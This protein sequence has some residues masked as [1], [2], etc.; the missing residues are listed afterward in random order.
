MT[1]ERA[2]VR[3]AG[4]AAEQ[5]ASAVA[6]LRQLGVADRPA[7]PDRA[8]VAVPLP[9]DRQTGPAIAVV[10][11]PGRSRTT[12]ELLGA[13][14][15]MAAEIRGRVVAVACQDVDTAELSARGA[16]GVIH[17]QGAT[18][19][20][21][22]ARGLLD[23]CYQDPPWA[24]LAPSTMWGRE[25]CGR[26]AAHLGAG[27]TGDAVDLAV[28]GGRLVGWKP[29]FGG[30]V[31]AAITA[32]SEIQL[33]TVR[34]GM[35]PLPRRRRPAP[36]A[37]TRR[38]V[39]PRGRVVERESYRDDDYDTLVT[40]GAVV[41]VGA[42]VAPEEYR[43]LEPLLGVLSAEL[44]GTR[45]V[46][47]KGWLPRA[48]Q[49][50]ITGRSI[51]PRLYMGI[52]LSGK[53]NHMVGVRGAGVIL[54]INS[55]PEAVVFDHADLGLVGD[56]HEVVPLLTK[57]LSAAAKMPEGKSDGSVVPGTSTGGPHGGHRRSRG[58]TAYPPAAGIA[59]R[60]GDPR[61]GDHV[62][63]QPGPYLPS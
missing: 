62:G 39:E 55:D 23:V 10:V 58:G 43:L 32:E 36:I 20:E 9:S 24:L 63:R 51:A 50:G 14:A 35:L 2:R 30:A 42:G 27:L 61:K 59:E 49:I 56:W 37:C 48:R 21:D 40:A 31:V 54:A 33:V 28:E 3:F 8:D 52:A 57:A 26:V 17:L 13:A 11:E 16:D 5:V 41:G 53:F 22:V 45:K 44:G 46:T 12:A 60:S 34:P 1:A 4:T 18:V 38:R 7:A 47:D 25:V 6:E 19:E 15:A 29:A